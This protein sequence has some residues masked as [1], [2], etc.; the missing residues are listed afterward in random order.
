MWIWITCSKHNDNQGEILPDVRHIYLVLDN[1]Y[2]NAISSADSLLCLCSMLIK[3]I[4]T[5]ARRSS[6]LQLIRKHT[7]VLSNTMFKT[8]NLQTSGRIMLLHFVVKYKT[9]EWLKTNE[10]YVK[11]TK[12][13]PD[14]IKG[15]LSWFGYAEEKSF[16]PMHLA[17]TPSPCT[18]YSLDANTT[19]MQQVYWCHLHLTSLQV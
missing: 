4:V 19:Y 13:K 2:C 17:Y 11:P 15:I 9:F 16:E 12:P 8:M 5:L 7:L 6:L 18:G 10:D 14:S 3:W 1:N